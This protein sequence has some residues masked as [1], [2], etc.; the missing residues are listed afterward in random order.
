MNLAL[1]VIIILLWIIISIMLEKAKAKERTIESE[2]EKERSELE[3]DFKM[4]EI[5]AP[6]AGRQKKVMEAILANV[7][8]A[9]LEDGFKTFIGRVLRESE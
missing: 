1:M 8:T 5:L 3:R 6:L 4:D 7:P 2:E 9:Q